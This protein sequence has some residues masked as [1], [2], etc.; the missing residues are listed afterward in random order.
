MILISK[1]YKI[2]EHKSRIRFQK[3]SIYLNFLIRFHSCCNPTIIRNFMLHFQFWESYH[4][5]EFSDARN[6][7]SVPFLLNLKNFSKFPSAILDPLLLYI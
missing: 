1:F 4:R 6:F 7:K 3:F 2:V 5:F